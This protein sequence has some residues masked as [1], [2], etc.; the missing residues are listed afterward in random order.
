VE[1]LDPD[2]RNPRVTL[3]F[4]LTAGRDE[5]FESLGDLPIPVDAN[6]LQPPGVEEQERELE[7]RAL[8]AEGI[9]IGRQKLVI[10]AGQREVTVQFAIC[11]NGSAEGDAAAGGER[12]DDGALLDGD[13]CDSNCTP[14]G[15]GNGVHHTA[16]FCLG[17]PRDVDALPGP[18][19]AVLADFDGDGFGDLATTHPDNDQ[20]LLFAGDGESVAALP[21]ITADTPIFAAAADVAGDARPDLVGLLRP[22]QTTLL[23][24]FENVSAAGGDPVDDDLFVQRGVVPIGNVTAI[25]LGDLDGDGDQDFA[26]VSPGAGQA[27]VQF[28]DGAGNFGGR[29]AF[30]VGSQPTALALADLDSDGDLDLVVVNKGSNSVSVLGNDGAGRFTQALGGTVGVGQGPVAVAVGDVDGD[31]VLDIVVTNQG[32]G[33]VSLLGVGDGPLSYKLKTVLS[34]GPSPV[35]VS[36]ADFN[37]DGALDIVTLNQ[38]E[39]QATVLLN[40]GGRQF[41]EPQRFPAGARP[42]V[43]SVADFNADGLPDIAAVGDEGVVLL[44]SAP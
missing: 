21:G 2:A 39:D 33:D 14:T 36:C 43:F 6:I 11:S 23:T 24:T 12:C 26:G 30:T 5:F 32:S 10:A 38:G 19:A 15:C 9:E 31:S 20:I 34:V 29:V 41:S 40:E 1:S 37:L 7:V 42:A 4:V 13:G 3:E 35:A 8:S 28:N 16:E 22:F 25:A 27:E 44:L 17:E 18:S